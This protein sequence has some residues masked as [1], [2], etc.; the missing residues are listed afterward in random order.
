MASSGMAEGKA[1]SR[2]AIAYSALDELCRSAALALGCEAA[3]LT[4]EQAGVKRVIA[5]HGLAA[6]YKSYEFDFAQSQYKPGDRL[7]VPDVK[8]GG[9]L[10]AI[11][12][13]LG[14]HALGFFLREPVLVSRKITAALLVMGEKAKP[15]A[16]TRK[17]TGLAGILKLLRKELELRTAK[18]ADPHNDITIV[19][20]LP[21]IESE[22][23]GSPE[24]RAL[25]DAGLKIVA[26]SEPLA[27]L[28]GQ[29][30]Q[31]LI[32]KRH[33][34]VSAPAS[35]AIGW[36]YER[37]L[38][39]RISPPEFEVVSEGSD[40][41]R[42]VYR[43]HVSP[44]SPTD[45][46]DYFLFVTIHDV[47]DLTA[48]RR[49]LDSRISKLSP[50]GVAPQEPSLLFLMKTL[51]PRRAIHERNKVSYL[52][53]MSWRHAIRTYQIEALKALKQNIP[54]E[55][56]AQ[57]AATMAG[58]INSLVGSGAFRAIVPMPCGHSHEESCLSRE[59]ARSLG[60]SVGL[61]VV[62]ALAS[63]PQKGS[64]HPK[65]NSRRPPMKLMEKLPGPVILVDDVATSGAHVEEAIKLLKPVCGAVLA[66]VWISG[67][68]V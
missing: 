57:V 12:A 41:I 13:R 32:G 2:G 3:V 14:F 28:L 67:D 43:L 16:E 19:G 60:A 55:L 11:A 10:S 5:S 27:R 20:T 39:T 18:L 66:V 15:P 62:A 47:T 25:L 17:R 24:P 9:E 63:S 48:Q 33:A 35:E 40:G 61:P 30:R 37:A 38:A 26:I 36:L 6:R 21:E 23:N 34:E 64:S 45:T 4:Y 31:K 46:R 50:K 56:P 49:R 22:V 8:P 44:F 1:S 53:L 65:K 59:L 29:S 58:E 42:H 51:V 54:P 52:T 7:L 68:K